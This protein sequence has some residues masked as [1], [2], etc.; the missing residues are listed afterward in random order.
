MFMK[1]GTP[2]VVNVTVLERENL[3]KGLY[4]QNQNFAKEDWIF[5]LT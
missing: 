5:N 3:Q 1:G 4:S 2:W